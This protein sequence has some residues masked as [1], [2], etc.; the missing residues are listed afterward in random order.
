MACAISCMISAVFVIGMIYF[1]YMTDKTGIAKQ[2][3]EQLSPE[4]Q[5]RYEKIV[6]ERTTISYYGYGLGLLL[7]IFIILYNVQFKAVKMNS[8]ALVCTVMATSFLTNYFFYMLYP[9]TDTML[10]YIHNPE[11]V[12]AWLKMYKGMQ[13]NY[14]MGLV[15]G[16]I[17][18][19]VFGFAFRC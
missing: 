17:S 5:K 14:H 16:I 7:S 9:K 1:Y 2:Y 3:K 19:G 4:L 10:N 6:K 12:N 15:L 13:Y 18:V 11:E 8:A